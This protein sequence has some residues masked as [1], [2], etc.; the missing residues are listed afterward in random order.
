MKQELNSSQCQLEEMRA[1]K[2]MNHKQIA[3]LM[4]DNKE[5]RRMNESQCEELTEMNEKCSQL[6]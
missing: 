6:R 3:D 5:L 2:V 1:E 4:R